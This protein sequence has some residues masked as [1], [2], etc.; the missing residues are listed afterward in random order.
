VDERSLFLAAG[1]AI[2]ATSV[3]MR[4]RAER[5]GVRLASGRRPWARLLRESGR[6]P[7]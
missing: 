1:D 3:P 4:R 5:V 6:G 2:V 7:G